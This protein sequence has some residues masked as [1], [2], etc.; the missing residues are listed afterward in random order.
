MC[1]CENENI[2]I[3][4]QFSMHEKFQFYILILYNFHSFFILGRKSPRRLVVV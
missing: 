4:G 3:S 2:N 1:V